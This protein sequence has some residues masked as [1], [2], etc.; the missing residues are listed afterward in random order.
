MPVS[1]RERL[2]LAPEE[3]R[4]RCDPATLGF[5]STREVEP[6]DGAAGQ[7]RAL[8]ALDFA[9][10]VSQLGYNVFATGPAGTS[11]RETIETRLGERARTQPPPVDAVF[12]FNFEDPG[13]PL[14]V[15]LPPGQ[16]RRLARTMAAFV[17]QAAREIPNAFESESYRRRR[18]GV[19]E[20]FEHEREAMLEQVRSFARSR[21]LEL[22]VTPAGVASV[23]LVHGRPVTPQE[24]QQL[25]EETRHQLSA[26]GH[27]VEERMNSVVP[28]LRELEARAGERVR[29]LDREVVLFAVG[30]LIDEVKQAHADSPALGAWLERAREDVVDNYGGFLADAEQAQL[31]APVRAM[32][33]H[34]MEAFRA[35]YEVNPFVTG[36]QDGAPVVVERN[37]TF[38]RLFGRIEFETTLG[39]AI[40]DHRHIKPGSIH[41]ASGGYMILRAED[42]LRQPFVWERLKEILRTGQAR[43][44]N[45]G[46][47]FT[48]FPTATLTPDPVPVQ[49][50]IVLTGSVELYELLHTLDEDLAELFRVRADFD[51]QMPWEQ[52]EPAQYAAYIS[53][54]VARDG[55]LHFDAGAVA[56]VVEDGARR[57]ADQG[58]LSTR[59]E[60]TANLLTEASHWAAQ[61]GSELVRA[62]H[63]EQAIRERRGRSDLIEQRLAEMVDE[64][65]VHI[66]LRGSSVGQLNGLAVLALGDYEFGHPTRITATTAIGGGE[67]VSID[68]ESKLTG[69]IHDKGFLTLRGY[70]EQRYGGQ[71]PLALSASLTFEQSYGG[72]EGDSASSAELY[73]LL[74]SLAVAPIDQGIAVTGSVDQYGRVQA[75][76]GVTEKVEG[77]FAACERA[78]LTGAQGVIIPASNQRHLMLD[79]QVV[80]AVREGRFH[81]WATHS[82]DEGIELLTGL[83]A[84]ERA[85]DGTYP[86]GTIHRR[87]HDRLTEM[88]RAAREWGRDH[89][90]E[91]GRAGA[92]EEHR[93]RDALRPRSA[94]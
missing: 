56:R 26:A 22:E 39:A 33:G 18:A 70:L 81:V 47:Q 27:E 90:G 41:A 60:D 48:L 85:P 89:R 19:T 68:R 9:V 17:T 64:G 50:K 87:A 59:Y 75:V 62:E 4:R 15:T 88:A 66:E 36:E 80:A 7:H 69:K 53:S 61:T 5:R 79:E 30:H 38:A 63:V 42:V 86:E 35:R 32:L 91:G 93:G 6:R 24:F 29:V 21:G 20:P 55:L 8:R 45:L 44:E 13:R 82:V 76:G 73:A 94:P 31:A 46:E 3:L 16:G 2:R 71:L 54:L 78:G 74:S 11:K 65:T 28:A 14:C 40:T 23:P 57:A 67:V 84:G 34:S 52:E 43:V 25:P 37:P 83:P 51:V 10:E 1:A 77:F 92:E 58:K 12:L 72:L 49:V